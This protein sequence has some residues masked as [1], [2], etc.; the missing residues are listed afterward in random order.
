MKQFKTIL[1]ATALCIGTVSFTQAQSKVAH[2]NTQELISAMPEMK[3]A[4][5]QLETLGKTYQTDIQTMATEFQ[6]K[7]KQYDA[8]SSTKTQEE[9]TKRAQEV[10]TMEQNIRQFQGQA[11][12]DLQKKELELLQPITEKA[13]T[14]ILKVARAQGFEYVL[15][16]AQGVMILS[17][18]KNLLDD[19]KKELGI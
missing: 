6:N 3:A 18:G 4:Q 5:A 11:Q 2:I 12:Q 17:D 7:V 8:E 14:A 19:V 9:N 1:L 13:K 16:S 15:D 10:Q